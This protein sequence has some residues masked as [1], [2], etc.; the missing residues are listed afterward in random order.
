MRLLVLGGT[1][2]LGGAV[3]AHAVSL[4]HEVTCLARGES[5]TVPQGATL[6]VADRWQEGA[7]HGLPEFDAA[8]EVSWQPAL[9][10]SALAAVQAQHWVYVSSISV[11]DEDGSLVAPWS[12]EGAVGRED[13]PGAKVACERLY[14]GLEPSRL[15]LARAGLIGGYGDRSDRL[16]YWPARI[17][18]ARGD[19]RSVLVPPPTPVQVVDVLDLAAWLVHCA[20]NRVAGTFD[21]VGPK[22]SLQQVLDAS[23]AA[24]GTDPEFVEASVEDLLA[25]G[26]R[27]WMGAD[28]LPLWT[29]DPDPADMA[30]DPGPAVAAGLSLRSVEETVSDALRWERELGIDR[31]R[32]SGLS[33]E[34]EIAVLGSL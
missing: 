4:G 23:A 22:A 11:Y 2:W 14:D 33:A 9:V 13:Y 17:D 26:V 27:P 5:G 19:R 7:Y 24:A 30:I 12:G 10:A 16:G 18:A 28:S 21:A 20:T 8:I 25:G 1:S 15:V 6:V 31:E 29:G 32:T 34:R 3:A